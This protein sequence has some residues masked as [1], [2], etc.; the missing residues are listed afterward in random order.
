MGDAAPRGALHHADVD[1]VTESP[2]RTPPSI[3][4]RPARPGR[5]LR[6]SQWPA[7]ARSYFVLRLRLLIVSFQ[8]VRRRMGGR[9]AKLRNPWLNPAWLKVARC[10]AED[11]WW[12]VE[13]GP[14]DTEDYRTVLKCR[15]ALAR[16]HAEHCTCEVWSH[17]PVETVAIGTVDHAT[18]PGER[19]VKRAEQRV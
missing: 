18:L 14:D 17:E 11:P 9:W 19:I 12:R 13:D 1:A 10:P 16:E 5:T 4:T 8:A 3:E 15:R 2:Y 6:L 7:Y